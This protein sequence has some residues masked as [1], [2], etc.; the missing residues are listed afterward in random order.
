MKNFYLLTILFTLFLVSSCSV[1]QQSYSYEHHG[2]DSIRLDS[3][4]KYVAR[5]V[6]GKA[7]T[8]IKMSAWK[9]M[10]QE[11]ALNGLMTKAKENLPVLTDNQAFANFSIDRLVTTTGSP[12]SAGVSATSITVEIVI[13]T[14]IIEYY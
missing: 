3:D 4:F 2:T 10:K 5:N 11:M 8:T 6:T 14:D 1:T 7:K 12:T 13:S 9:K